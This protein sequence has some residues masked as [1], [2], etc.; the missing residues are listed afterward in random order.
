M[1]GQGAE[2]EDLRLN[3]NRWVENGPMMTVKHEKRRPIAM[4]RFVLTLGSKAR[5]EA[6][7]LIYFP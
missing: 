3:P 5:K 1:F 6:K 7:G 4:A 2:M